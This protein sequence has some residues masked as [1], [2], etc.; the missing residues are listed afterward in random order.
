MNGLDIVLFLAGIISVALVTL[1]FLIPVFLLMIYKNVKETN[2]LLEELLQEVRMLNY[3]NR[4][5]ETEECVSP[6]KDNP[7]KEEKLSKLGELFLEL[8]SGESTV[9]FVTIEEEN[10]EIEK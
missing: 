3:L 2:N 10:E 5:E 9:E 6:D 1:A 4:A 8:S 7:G